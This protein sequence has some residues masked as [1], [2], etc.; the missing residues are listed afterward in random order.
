[1]ILEESHRSSLSIH[2]RATK[3]YHDLKKLFWF[4]LSVKMFYEVEF[5]DAK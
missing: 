4:G 2:P 3:I 1:M 5:Q